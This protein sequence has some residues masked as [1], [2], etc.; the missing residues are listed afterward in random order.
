MSSSRFLDTEGAG[1][2]VGLSPRSLEGLRSRGGGPRYI[3]H[4]GQ[5]SG[6]VLYRVQDLDCWLE[7]RV[8]RSTS[9]PGPER[10]GDG[11]LPLDLASAGTAGLVDGGAEHR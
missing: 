6:R 2:Y 10:E 11:K 3:K 4:G 7:A 8:R 1:A 9:D 5:G